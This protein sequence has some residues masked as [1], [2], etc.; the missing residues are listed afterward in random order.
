MSRGRPDI[1]NPSA[2]LAQLRRKP[3]NERKRPCDIDVELATEFGE[4]N[5][6]ERPLDD[7]AGAVDEGVEPALARRLD[8]PGDGAVDGALVGKVERDS[9]DLV[10]KQRVPSCGAENAPAVLRQPR[11][12]PPADSAARAGYED[13]PHRVAPLR[14]RWYWNTDSILARC[15]QPSRPALRRRQRRDYGFR[16][17]LAGGGGLQRLTRSQSQ[18]R[19]RERLLQRRAKRSSVT[20]SPARAWN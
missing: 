19:T 16:R 7:H 15:C 20:A 5:E 2:R 18:A 1:D 3:A 17:T 10:W 14:F 8:D 6:L 13:C 4:R 9:L 11:G 12:Q